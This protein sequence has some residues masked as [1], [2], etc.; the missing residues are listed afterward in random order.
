MGQLPPGM[1]LCWWEIALVVAL[2]ALPT[3][4]IRA[5]NLN[6]ARDVGEI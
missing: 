6:P 2:I 1:Q 5:L 4:T 3:Q